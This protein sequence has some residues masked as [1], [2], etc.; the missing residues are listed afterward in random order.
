MWAEKLNKF[1][2]F[3]RFIST[4]LFSNVNYRVTVI[5]KLRKYLAIKIMLNKQV[6]FRNQI[7]CILL[8][9]LLLEELSVP[10][11]ISE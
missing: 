7:N 5:F 4:R 9:F 11:R 3:K 2:C 10:L 8:K 1:K 6:M